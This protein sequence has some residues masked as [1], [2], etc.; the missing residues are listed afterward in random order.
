LRDPVNTSSFVLEPIPA[1]PLAVAGL[2]YAPAFITAEEEASLLRAIA[3]LPLREAQYKQYTARRRIASFGASYDFADNTL[4]EAPPIPDFLLPLR[5]RVAQWLGLA[6]EVF[7]QALLTEYRPGTELG[8]HRDVPQFGIVAGISLGSACR[9]RFRPWPVRAN[10][11]EGAFTL[12]L[13]PRSAYVLRG[14]ARWRWQH[15]IAPTPALRHSV[16]LRTKASATARGA[17]GLR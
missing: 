7:T 8:W 5:A 17:R 9:M 10:P 15:S 1:V 6:E 11:R 13:A 12:E 2:A 3:A 4:H 14:D 16:T